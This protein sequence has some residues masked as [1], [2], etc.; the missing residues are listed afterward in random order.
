MTPPV[1][2]GDSGMFKKVL[3]PVDQSEQ[4]RAVGRWAVGLA[5]ATKAE[6]T[7]LTG[8]DSEDILFV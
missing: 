4:S 6:V 8:I 1:A 2:K 3:V 7:L 5:K